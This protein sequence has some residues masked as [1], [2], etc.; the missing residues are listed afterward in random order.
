M[1]DVFFTADEHYGH[2]NIRTGWDGKE[3]S[4]APRPFASLEEMTEGLIE[5]NNAVVKPGDL[6]YHLGDMFWRTF[7]PLD[8]LY[9]MNSLNGNHYYIRGNHEEA[10]DINETLKWKFVWIRERAKINPVGGPAAGIVLDHYA[11]RVWNGSH[12]GSWQ[13]YGHSHGQLPES[14]QLLSFDV[15][16]DCNNYT[17]VSL[18]QARAHMA[19][20]GLSA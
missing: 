9:V 10:L 3:G 16:V 19:L 13:L 20:K 18:E 6:V 5:R 11:G 12:K 8:A 1:N 7:S 2:K 15:G 4:V 14:P 17:P